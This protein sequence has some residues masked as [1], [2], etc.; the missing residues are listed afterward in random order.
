MGQA[1]SFDDLQV[2]MELPAVT[3]GPITTMDL[4]KWAG[5]SGDYNPIHYDKDVALAQGLPA[6]VI[7]GPYRLALAAAMITRWAGPAGRIR[8]IECSYRGLDLPGDTMTCGAK[9][10]SRS[11]DEKGDR[12]IEL[13][14]WVQNPREKST[15]GT[16][17]VQWT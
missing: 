2:N 13:E 3:V 11:V 1:L 9:I 4:V 17:K 12:W 8:R 7:P 5:A 10:V 16:A 15:T 14:V 6:V